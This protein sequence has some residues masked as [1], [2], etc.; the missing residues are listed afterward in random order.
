M[1]IYTVQYNTSDRNDIYVKNVVY[2]LCEENLYVLC[3]DIIECMG[4]TC[5][6]N[7]H[8]VRTLIID[9]RKLD[10]KIEI[11]E[12]VCRYKMQRREKMSEE[13]ESKLLEVI[14]DEAESYSDDSLYN[15]TSFGTDLSFR[16][17][18]LMY[19]EGDLEKPELQRKYVWTKNEASRFVDSILLGLPVPSVFLAKTPDNKRLIVDGYQRIMTV[20]DYMEGIFSG[21][22]KV[23]RLSNSDN[24]HPNWRGRAYAELTEEQRRIIRNY[25]IHAI[26]FEQKHPQNDT[27]MYQIFERIN[28]SGR[29]LKPQ[30]IRNCVYHGRYNKLLCDLN[31]EEIWRNIVGSEVEDSRMADIELILRFFAF[32]NILDRE[33]MGQTQINL[34]K[35]LNV[36]MKERSEDCAQVLEEDKELFLDVMNFLYSSIGRNVFRAGKEKEG[37]FVWAKK[38][39]PVVFDAVCA[40]TVK[41]G[42]QRSAEDLLVK[43]VRLLIDEEFIAATKQR[44][45]NTENI[46]KRISI[47]ARILYGVEL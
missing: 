12:I 4:D 1:P 19:K 31:K 2:L 39:N 38:I 42:E 30:E 9:Y 43:Y 16:E 6:L 45:T 17:L 33:E 3:N 18:V 36:F 20:Y 10:N 15:I 44:T 27:G 26:I 11:S 47:A 5:G 28:T 21:D 25:P 41:A 37:Q 40:A 24:I 14:K 34:I 35:Y 8:T 23:F 32:S 46:K 29:A 7:T 22:G 13:K